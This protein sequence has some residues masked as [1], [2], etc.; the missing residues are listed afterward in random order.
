MGKSVLILQSLE[1]VIRAGGK[2]LIFTMEMQREEVLARLLANIDS[3]PM[4]TALTGYTGDQYANKLTL[5]KIKRAGI[6]MN[7]ADITIYDKGD[8]SIAYIESKALT[9]NDKKQI[10]VI[11]IDYWQLIESPDHK[12]ELKRLNYT[13]RRLKTLAKLVKAPVVT[14]SQ[15][16]EDNKTKDSKAMIA[17]ANILIRVDE[18]GLVVDK[19]RNSARGQFIPVKLDG[20][21]QRFS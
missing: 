10:D 17:E 15:L 21:F 5:D 3:V 1:P 11:G 13:S 16:N 18:E 2:V 8:Q 14:G 4:Q 12:E 7:Q 19:S 9:Q 6:L 20:Q